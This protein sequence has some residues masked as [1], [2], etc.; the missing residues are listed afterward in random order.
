MKL[1]KSSESTP[2]PLPPTKPAIWSGSEQLTRSE[3]DSLRQGKK[4]ISD[5]VQRVLGPQIRAKL[6]ADASAAN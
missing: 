4:H 5:Y 6:A 3:I 2:Q 1:Q